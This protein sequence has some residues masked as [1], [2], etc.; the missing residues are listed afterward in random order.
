M[1]FNPN[2]YRAIPY[3]GQ[4]FF[5][6]VNSPIARNFTGHSGQGMGPRLVPLSFNW[7]TYFAA[8]GNAE[9]IAVPVNIQGG[10]VQGGILDQ[11]LMVKI[12]NQ[13]ST[14][15]IS[16][17]FPDTQDMVSCP[18]QTVVTVPAMTNG[19]N[20]V[21]IA[22][23]LSPGFTP[24]TMVYLYNF[25]VPS[26]VDPQ[27]QLT[28]PQWR[29]SPTVQQ[30]YNQILTPG[31][32]APALGD[33]NT[34]NAF[35]LNHGA[36]TVLW[37][38]I[39]GTPRSDYKYVYLTHAHVS[40]VCAAEASQQNHFMYMQALGASS[41]L[42]NFYYSTNPIPTSAVLLNASGMNLKLDATEQWF[43]AQGDT[44]VNLGGYLN[45]YFAY[46]LSND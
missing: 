10:K 13:N 38:N 18:P 12:D 35:T 42:W 40:L 6:P 45:V 43:W 15:P 39:F 29:G 4:P 16:V 36:G 1:S 14:V 37:N 24:E 25:I 20:L 30:G 23:G 33:Q 46:T 28:F 8:A 41:V 26:V 9:N 3:I 34:S 11:I 5:N 27:I 32:G 44:G 19:L 17:Y 7:T 22:Q 2:S 21:V 31:Y